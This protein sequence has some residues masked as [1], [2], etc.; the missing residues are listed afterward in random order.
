LKQTLQAQSQSSY[1]WLRSA[2]YLKWGPAHDPLASINMTTEASASDGPVTST[3]TTSNVVN[4]SSEKK[5]VTLICFNAPSQLIDRFQRLLHNVEW[6]NVL[7]NPFDLWVV[8]ID[9]L[10]AQ[11]DAQAWNVGDVFRGIERVSEE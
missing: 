7:E 10:F 2:F 4:S 8:V 6:C 1:S 11:M 5:C 9:E 3:P